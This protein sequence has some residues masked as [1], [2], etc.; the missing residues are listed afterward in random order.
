M[1]RFGA[2][3]EA[4]TH[5]A[6]TLGLTADLLPVVSN[7]HAE[8]SPNSK[9]KAIGK[10][11]SIYNRQ[12]QVA[13]LPEWTRLAA[14]EHLVRRWASEPDYGICIQTRA[15]RA[16][17]IDVADP[18]KAQAIAAAI[19][20]ITGALP[21]RFRSNSGKRLLAFTYHRPL[22][23]RFVPVDG[24]I[25][26]IL[27]DGQ[28]FIAA[29]AHIDSK[30]GFEGAFY[31]W[32][33]DMPKNFPVLNGEQVDKVW[34]MLTT[35]FATGE[36]RIAREKRKGSADPE[37][38]VHDDVADWL[39][40]KWETYDVGPDGQ[41]FIECPFADTH[42]ADSGPTATAYF[43]AGTGGFA[44]G[45]FVCLHAHCTER[46]DQDYLT[47]TGYAVAQFANLD[48]GGSAGNAGASEA[49]PDTASGAD[50]AEQTATLP[51]VARQASDQSLWPPL[52]RDKSG[53]IDPTAENLFLAIADGGM[54]HKHV[55]YDAFTDNIVWA[56][57]DRPKISAAWRN[58]GDAD[59]IALRIELERRGFKPMGKD[60]LR[61]AIHAAAHENRID[62]AIEWIGRLNWDGVPR[63][64]TFAIDC[65]GWE[66]TPYARAVSCY[67]WT[68]MAGRVLQPGVR[69]DMAPI[70]VGVQGIKKTTA[71]QM[72]VPHE[73]AYAEIKLTDKDD[74]LSRKLRG[75]LVGELEEL[76]GLNTRAIEEIKAFVSRRRE[77]W[78]PKYKEFEA[79]FWRR[80]ILIGSTNDD[81][82]LSDPTG[83]RRWLPGECG[84]LDIDYLI[85]VRDQLWA[86][87][88]L[89]FQ[90][91]GVEWEAAE[92]LAPA[93][94]GRFKVTDSWQ[95]AI[96]SW[97][98]TPQI[99]GALPLDKGYVS[100]HEILFAALGVSNAQQNRG[101][102]LRV[103]RALRAM[104]FRAIEN[105]DGKVYTR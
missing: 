90:V 2:P 59:M 69:A 54:I 28:Q 70:L 21:L 103:I 76:R 8:I 13:G 41:V 30:L 11:P 9:V 105:G 3:L 82:F 86:E 95:R 49:G 45:H 25:V 47:A 48:A 104:G 16:F 91:A 42:T 14:T 37:L 56:P 75:K 81:E 71:I 55:A 64:D 20:Q 98:E 23:K 66:D 68:A 58:F 12:R 38:I 88:A 24:G 72:M 33:G 84:Q 60:L 17:D 78:I 92:R 89:R 67:V 4:W 53:R 80:C 22:T 85:S 34:A 51:A 1:Q 26:E 96:S 27:G 10:T 5:F 74:D 101:H 46:E 93:E 63:I 15:V 7:P 18:V 77:A 32:A 31:E 79:F 40:E 36:P 39:V 73:D 61:D 35:I 87:G 94:H 97:L 43:P 6:D 83:E 102:E 57:F 62:T 99:G 44:R 65:W 52:I 50:V 19:V 100:T 29:G